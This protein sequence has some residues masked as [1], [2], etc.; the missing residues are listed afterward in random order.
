VDAVM[1][2]GLGWVF[3]AGNFSII[4]NINSDIVGEDWALVGGV[5]IGY[6]F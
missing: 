4:P 3:H 1:R 5:T 2:L 6:R